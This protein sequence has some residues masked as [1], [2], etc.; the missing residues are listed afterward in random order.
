MPLGVR[1]RRFGTWWAALTRKKVRVPG[2]VKAGGLSFPAFI[3]ALGVGMACCD[4]DRGCEAGQ[5]G[6]ACFWS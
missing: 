4:T 6:C 1:E 3:S 5:G 2:P